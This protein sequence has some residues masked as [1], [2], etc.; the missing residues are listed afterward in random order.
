[1]ARMNYSLMQL[2]GK[3]ILDSMRIKQGEDSNYYGEFEL[4]DDYA[5][6]G[7]SELTYTPAD[8][9]VSPNRMQAPEEDVIYEEAYYE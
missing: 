8:G 2:N 3:R 7:R 4:A 1:M 5:L 9:G 6:W